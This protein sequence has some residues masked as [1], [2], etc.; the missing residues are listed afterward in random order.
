MSAM[1]FCQILY[2]TEGFAITYK[3]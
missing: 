1:H 3:M 2:L